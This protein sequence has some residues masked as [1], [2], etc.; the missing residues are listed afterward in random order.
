FQKV[1][2]IHRQFAVKLSEPLVA[3]GEKC[4]HQKLLFVFS[5]I[6]WRTGKIY[7]R[8]SFSFPKKQKLLR[9]KQTLL[10]K[11]QLVFCASGN[12]RGKGL[13]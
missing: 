12:G 3:A 6:A 2:G 4:I 8:K 5:N 9:K 13:F 7:F 11:K 1:I 10:Q